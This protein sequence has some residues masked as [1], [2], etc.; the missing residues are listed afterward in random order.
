MMI[1][2][3][4]PFAFQLSVFLSAMIVLFAANQQMAQAQKAQPVGI[5]VVEKGKTKVRNSVGREAVYDDIGK[6]FPVY[7][8]DVVQTG[9]ATRAKVTFRKDQEE[10]QLYAKTNF[11]VDQVNAQN[12]K[13]G[14]NVGKAFFK[15]V[16]GIRKGGFQVRTPT[17]TIGIKGTEWVA[18]TDGTNTYVVTTEGVVSMVNPDFPDMEI[19]VPANTASV[20]KINRPPSPPVPVTEEIK[21]EIIESEG[22]ESFSENVEFAEP[23]PVE[24]SQEEGQGEDDQGA[25]ETGD[26]AETAT[27]GIDILEVTETVNAVQSSV[28]D[29]AE[30]A[31]AAVDSAQAVPVKITITR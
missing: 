13:F 22:V 6:K 16:S 1:Y 29:S 14:L 31:A 28:S 25:D 15:A 17:A 10:I 8:G 27:A 23:P 3:K 30:S 26:D 7:Q 11:K 9:A 18:G 5:L 20:V 21:A 2:K 12:S 4:I 19:E 24:G